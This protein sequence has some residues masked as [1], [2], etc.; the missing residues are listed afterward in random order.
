MA[1]HPD[2]INKKYAQENWFGNPLGVPAY[3]HMVNMY[4]EY[5]NLSNTCYYL[6]EPDEPIN[7][8]LVARLEM[9]YDANRN[10]LT[11]SRVV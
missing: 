5:Q 10:L 7:A 9:T 4:D 11:L 6:G 1:G 2:S 8:N 3:D